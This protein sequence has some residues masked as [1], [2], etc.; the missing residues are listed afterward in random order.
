MI[1]SP[2]QKLSV[3]GVILAA[4][5]GT[6]MGIPKAL[7]RAPDGASWLSRR[8][9]DLLVA[10]CEEVLVVLGAEAERAIPLVNAD[11]Y[12]VS[13][14]W[15]EGISASLRTGLREISSRNFDAALIQ[16]VDTPDIGTDVVER[17]LKR[18][19][20]ASLARAVYQGVPGHPV[21]IG[22]E[23]WADL[24]E[25]LSGNSGAKAYLQRNGAARIECGDLATGVDIDTP[26]GLRRYYS[27]DRPSRDR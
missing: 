26:D 9:Q 11:W 27:Q 19:N 3:V 24:Q 23:H 7:V 22:R 14:S 12:V 2:Q 5:A 18:A 13:T 8:R 6:R 21:L 25:T 1:D 4:G 20:P 15:S 17:V 10:G 16:L